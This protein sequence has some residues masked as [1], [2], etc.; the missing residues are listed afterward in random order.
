[1]KV[2]MGYA[3]AYPQVRKTQEETKKDK[4]EDG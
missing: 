4:E 2:G 3:N 1:M